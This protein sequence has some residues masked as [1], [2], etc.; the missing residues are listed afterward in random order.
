[1]G[2]STCIR[3]PCPDKSRRWAKIPP[4]NPGH[5]ATVLVTF[6]AR[7]GNPTAVRTGKEINVPPPAT[8]FT[9]PAAIAARAIVM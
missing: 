6:A 5:K 7:G 8:A 1:M 9:A 3:R 4:M 2:S